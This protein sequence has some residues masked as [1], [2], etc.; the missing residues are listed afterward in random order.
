MEQ[1]KMSNQ[2]W[3]Y[4]S[5][6]LTHDGNQDGKLSA[7]VWPGQRCGPH[8]TGLTWTILSRW[9]PLTMRWKSKKKPYTGA[10][11]MLVLMLAH[12]KGRGRSVPNFPRGRR[13]FSKTRTWLQTRLCRGS[14]ARANVRSRRAPFHISVRTPRFLLSWRGARAADVAD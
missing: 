6:L 7:R 3:P 8:Q 4:S 12:P 13:H 5:I 10:C 2:I 14:G 1:D 9:L 11:G